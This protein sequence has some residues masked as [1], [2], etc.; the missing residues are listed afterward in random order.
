MIRS[1]G[2]VPVRFIS[3]V[4]QYL[5]LK[6]RSHWDFPKGV[7]EAGETALS[8]AKREL[9]EESDLDNPVFRWGDKF[10]I[11][12]PYS[13]PTKTARYYVAEISKDATVSLKPNPKTGIVEHESFGWFGFEETRL[14]LKPRI[15]KVL[16]W[17]KGRIDA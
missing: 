12:K 17:A 6:N 15:L 1:C 3:G 4:A 10:Y 13:T 14:L 7:M 8:C 5:L 9:L 2:I 16:I 11:T